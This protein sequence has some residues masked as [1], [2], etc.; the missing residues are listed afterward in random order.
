MARGTIS[1]CGMPMNLT[2]DEP[3]AFV[4][5]VMA[6]D[7]EAMQEA[8]GA[9]VAEFGE[10]RLEGP[11]YAFD[12]TEYYDPEMGPGLTK[13]LLWLGAPVAPAELATRKRTTISLERVRAHG[14]S[15]T[16]N[17]DPGLL[18]ANSLVLATTKMSGHR[19]CI[20]SG[21]WA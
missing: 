9:L 18:S 7:P 5:A 3:V 16:V 4:C 1:L 13:C 11:R 2:P 20:A 6:P 12:M 17:I 15:R 21:L 19:F 14:D 10:V 8:I